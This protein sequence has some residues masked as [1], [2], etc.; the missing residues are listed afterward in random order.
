MKI[1]IHNEFVKKVPICIMI[2][3][4]CKVLKNKG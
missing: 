1:V 4:F 2:I 3:S